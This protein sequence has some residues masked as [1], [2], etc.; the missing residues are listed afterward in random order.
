MIYSI[1]VAFEDGSCINLRYERNN[2]AQAIVRARADIGDRFD[3]AV[4]VECR[5]L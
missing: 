3:S 4:C 2:M 5:R 1:F